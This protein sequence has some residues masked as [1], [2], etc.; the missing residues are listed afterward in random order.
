MTHS[1]S[2]PGDPRGRG[3]LYS[4]P[5]NGQLGYLLTLSVLSL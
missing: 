5:E 2:L 4:S 1:L 3:V